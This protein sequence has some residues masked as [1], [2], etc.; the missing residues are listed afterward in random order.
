MFY[1]PLLLCNGNSHIQAFTPLFWVT[2]S[3]SLPTWQVY[4]LTITSI[5]KLAKQHGALYI[6]TFYTVGL[7]INFSLSSKYRKLF[8]YTW[9]YTLFLLPQAPTWLCMMVPATNRWWPVTT[10]SLVRDSLHSTLFT[11]PPFLPLLSIQS[12]Q[13]S[14]FKAEL[15]SLP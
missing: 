10:E 14:E 13:A 11:R 5:C 12:W 3:S 2:C 1:S 15:F 6:V 9:R 4:E 8:C 7:L